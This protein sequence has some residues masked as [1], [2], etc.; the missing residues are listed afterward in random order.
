LDEAAAQLRKAL[1]IVPNSVA[2]LNNIANVAY[3]QGNNDE[4]ERYWKKSLT[5]S[6]DNPFAYSGLGILYHYNKDYQSATKYFL[7]GTQYETDGHQLWGRLG[8]SYRLIPDK[9]DEAIEV[10]NKA[11]NLASARAKVNP[12]DW[13]TQGYLALYNAYIGNLETSAQHLTKMMELN[14]TQDPQAHHWSALVAQQAGDDEEVFRQLELALKYGWSAQK[15][16]IAD[17]PALDTFKAAYPQRFADLL[18][19]Y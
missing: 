3:R 10:F 16:F 15:R 18:A 14:P 8:E 2:S 12:T 1:D 7:L 19:R 5:I 6:A 9:G 11:I 17:E 13:E 4:A